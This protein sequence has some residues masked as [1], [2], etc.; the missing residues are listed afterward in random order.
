MELIVKGSNAE[1]KQRK[2]GKPL[3]IPIA[4]KMFTPSR[5]EWGAIAAECQYDCKQL[6]HFFKITPRHLARKFAEE[7]GISP[8][9]WLDLQ[10]AIA[11]EHLLVSSQSVKEVGLS[12]GF[13]YPANFHRHF[14]KYFGIGPAQFLEMKRSRNNS[15]NVSNS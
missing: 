7:I 6:A 5:G 8:Q 9:G 13:R 14:K 12:L 4:R 1:Q 3:E 15:Q 2:A 10:R 11:A